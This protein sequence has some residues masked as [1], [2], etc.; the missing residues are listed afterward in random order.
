MRFK[1]K[2]VEIDAVQ[3]TGDNADD[4]IAWANEG[5]NGQSRVEVT[6]AGLVV[7]TLEGDMIA[8][9]DDWIIRGVKNEMYPC[10]PDIFALTYEAV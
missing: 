9:N 10:K 3:F 8:S 5:W 7:H 1:K 2:P 4:I 6:D